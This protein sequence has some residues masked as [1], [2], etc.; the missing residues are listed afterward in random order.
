MDERA[1][2]RL[3]SRSQAGDGK[4]F[5]ALFHAHRDRAYRL[6]HRLTGSHTDADDVL[7]EAWT[8]AF[9]SIIEDRSVGRS[10]AGRRPG[11]PGR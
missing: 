4:A 6:A 10:A 8:R 3:V 7:Q 5:Q 11:P 2:R 1:E 9:R